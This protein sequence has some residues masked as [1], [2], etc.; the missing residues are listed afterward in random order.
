VLHAYGTQC[1]ACTCSVQ[2]VPIHATPS[3]ALWDS[4]IA[5]CSNT[6]WCGCFEQIRPIQ[7]HRF[8]ALDA[9]SNTLFTNYYVVCDHDVQQVLGGG[10]GNRWVTRLRPV[11]QF[12]QLK[13]AISHYEKGGA[14]GAA[15]ETLST[16][17]LKR[18][19]VDQEFAVKVC[20]CINSILT[21]KLHVC[22]Q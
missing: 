18:A 8:L 17:L 2:L 14:E 20:V 3:L 7:F 21:V 12:A 22:I 1:A 6:L 10:V 19:G 4:R 11:A 16:K 13:M 5:Q 15:G 9:C